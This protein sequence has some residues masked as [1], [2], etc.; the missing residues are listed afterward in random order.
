MSNVNE[1]EV[2]LTNE[3]KETFKKFLI[4]EGVIIK[5]SYTVLVSEAQSRYRGRVRVE[6]FR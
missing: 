2:T 4:V 3:I 6:M 1:R 5:E